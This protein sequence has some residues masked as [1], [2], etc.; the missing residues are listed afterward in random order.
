MQG[1]RHL[2]A[3]PGWW[4]RLL[5]LLLLLQAGDEDFF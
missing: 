4:L 3:T 1:D 5:L 2:F